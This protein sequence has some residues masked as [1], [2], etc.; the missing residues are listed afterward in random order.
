[1]EEFLNPITGVVDVADVALL[2]LR[3]TLPPI[4]RRKD[5]PLLFGNCIAVGTLANLGQQG[6]PFFRQGRHVVY[7]RDSFLIW[8]AGILNDN[9]RK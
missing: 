9:A 6:P 7:E 2:N 3:K 1:M 4:F 8:Y 5:V